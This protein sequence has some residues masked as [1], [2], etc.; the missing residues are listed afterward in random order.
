MA[1]GEGEQGSPAG[2]LGA[3][4]RSLQ[5]RSGRTLRSLEAEVAISD[6]SLS[7]YFRGST[8]PPWST[9]RDLCRALGADPAEYRALWEAADRCQA[10]QPAGQ[11]PAGQAGAAPPAGTPVGPA[12]GRRSPRLP[13]VLRG[14]WV[15]AAAGVV[16]GLAAGGGLTALVLPGPTHTGPGRSTSGPGGP[17]APA[18]RIF[19]NRATGACLDDS[20]EEGVRSFKCNVLSY[21]LWTVRAAADGTWQL[22][23]HATGHCL[24]LTA[25]EVRTAAC[26]SVRTQRWKVTVLPD[27][28]TEVR[29]AATGGCLDDSGPGLGA[30]PCERTPRQKWA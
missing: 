22:R 8:V 12:A 10:K 7:R 28:A 23:N 1:D 21:Q 18:G 3:R 14:R 30:R 15:C 25:S 9:V 19:V 6:S 29:N 4:L 16:I 20:L 24:D 13:D 26:T 17:H 5:Q 11:Q 27:A 2:R